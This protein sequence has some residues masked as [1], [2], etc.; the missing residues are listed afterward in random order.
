MERSQVRMAGQQTKNSGLD[1]QGVCGWD[2]GQATQKQ[3]TRAGPTGD[4]ESRQ[5]FSWEQNG[6]N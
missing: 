5:P 1:K 3:D 4:M 6:R 2:R